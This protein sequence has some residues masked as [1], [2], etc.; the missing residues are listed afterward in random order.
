[1]TEIKVT[2]SELKRR[3][4]DLQQY[5][6]KFRSEVDK[7]VGY[8]QELAGMWEG[9]AQ[10]AFRKAFNEDKRKMDQFAQNIDSYIRALN[11]DADKYETAEQ[12]ATDIANTRKS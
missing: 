4:D 11:S 2:S 3:A 10:A 12:K 7:M 8:E 6:T 1:M 5:V 9:D